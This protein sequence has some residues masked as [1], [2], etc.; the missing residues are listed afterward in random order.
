MLPVFALAAAVVASPAPATTPEPSPVIIDT[1]RAEFVNY[2]PFGLI[3]S[4]GGL[5]IKFTNEGD[6]TIEIARFAV[7]F[8]KN[9]LNIRDVGTFS[10]GVTVDHRF[11]DLNG[12]DTKFGFSHED[13]PSSCTVF[14]LKYAD[15][16]MWETPNAG[17][18]IPDANV[19][20]S[21]SP[22]PSASSQ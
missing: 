3:K 14:F 21:P 12:Q 9:Q 6:K 16:T 10:P 4:V 13:Q 5:Q 18:D 7:V 15:G 22:A 19:T 20:P 1:C 11:R 17:V 2:G 8:D